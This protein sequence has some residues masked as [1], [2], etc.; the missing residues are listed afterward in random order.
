MMIKFIGTY[1][2]DGLKLKRDLFLA[3][4]KDAAIDLGS[5]TRDKVKQNK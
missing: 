2:K 1:P 5:S 3:V 4:Y